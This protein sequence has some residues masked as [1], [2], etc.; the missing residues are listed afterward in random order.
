MV[1]YI[2]LF[3]SLPHGIGALIRLCKTEVGIHCLVSELHVFLFLQERTLPPPSSLVVKNGLELSFVP[4]TLKAVWD[5]ERAEK[6]DKTNCLISD[7]IFN[8]CEPQFPNPQNE[9]KN[10]YYSGLL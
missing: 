8:L 4:N 6:S 5:R 2:Q 9:L 3:N 7:E 10:T 1:P